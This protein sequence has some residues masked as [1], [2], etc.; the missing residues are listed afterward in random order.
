MDK[1]N[2]NYLIATIKSWNI[3]RAHELI[4]NNP[5]LNIDLITDKKELTFNRLKNLNPRFVFFPHWS[6]II[7]RKIFENFE[8]VVFHM[9]DLPFGRGGSPLQNLIERGIYET[10][11]SALKVVKDLDAGPIYFKRDLTLEG[12]ATEIFCRASDIIF[13]EMI[14]EIIKNEPE[15]TPQKGKTTIFKRRIPE[16]SN[17]S[18]LTTS[19]KVYDYIRMLDAEGY[20]PAFVETSKLKIEFSQG[21]LNNGYVLAQAKIKVKNE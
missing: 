10:K 2:N 7:P 9:T 17:I 18:N 13:H 15:L 11:I 12:S 4:R 21:K 6:W 5:R 16:Q 8:C 14:P 3:Q 20:P 1:T 19:T